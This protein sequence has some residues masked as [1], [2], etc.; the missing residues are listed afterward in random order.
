MP[1]QLVQMLALLLELGLQLF[2]FQF[3]L[4]A[5]VKFFGG[6]FTFGERIARV[7]AARTRESRAGSSLT[8]LKSDTHDRSEPIDAGGVGEGRAE[9]GDCFMGCLLRGGGGG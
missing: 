7:L 6:P 3:L 4:L 2:Q 1:V 8:A 5:D 9:H